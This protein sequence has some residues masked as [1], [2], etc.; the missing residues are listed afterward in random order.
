M[1]ITD[2]FVFI[3]YPKTASAFTREALDELNVGGNFFARWYNKLFN[4][5][6]YPNT[7]LRIKVPKIEVHNREGQPT[8]HGLYI[9]IPEEHKGKRI[10]TV[11]RNPFDRL[12][13]LYTFQDWT[14]TNELLINDYTKST[15]PNYPNLTFDEYI[16]ALYRVNPLINDE[17]FKMIQDIGPLTIQF[18]LFYFKDP[19][20]VLN[21]KISDSYIYNNDFLQDMPTIFFAKMSNLNNDL[22]KFLLDIGYNPKQIAFLKTKQKTNISRIGEKSFRSYYS[23]EMYNFVS[24][25]ERYLLHF[26]KVFNLDY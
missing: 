4:H 22:S 19:Y 6:Y 3:V 10:F 2:D 7:Y 15:H 14:K 24:Q 17:K 16:D 13:S 23:D 26:C 12:L 1:I 20:T 5:Y 9:Q 18:I 8:E 21:E 25:K 11:S